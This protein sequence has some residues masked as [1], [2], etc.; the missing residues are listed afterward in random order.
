MG[1]LGDLLYS[2]NPDMA[3]QLNNK[4]DNLRKSNALHNDIVNS[5]RTIADQTKTFDGYLMA[6]TAMQYHIS[7]AQEELENLPDQGLPILS[8]CIADNVEE[9]EMDGLNIKLGYDFVKA[10]A[11]RVANIVQESGTYVSTIKNGFASFKSA[12][13]EGL[14][15]TAYKL[16]I[17]S[18]GNV[19]RLTASEGGI[20]LTAL[21]EEL[22]SAAELELSTEAVKAAESVEVAEVSQSVAAGTEAVAGIAEEVAVSGVALS[23]LLTPAAVVLFAVTEVISA[24]HAKQEHEKLKEALGKI[25]DLQ[26]K[27]DTSLKNLKTAFVSLLKSAQLDIENYNDI[28]K[29]LSA[30]EHLETYERSFKTTGIQAFS[31]NLPN[32]KPDSYNNELQGY[33]TA[34]LDNLN[35]AIEFIRNHALHDSKM[36]NIISKIRTHL[37]KTGETEVSEEFMKQLAD[38]EDVELKQVKTWNEFRKYIN[39]MASVLSRYHEAIKVENSSSKP[40]VRQPEKPQFG[41][42]NPN[43]DPNPSLFAI[44]HPLS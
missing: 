29:K 20:E 37:R 7:Y 34:V 22:G 24:I 2:D 14:E 15:R 5:Y 17:F 4:E 31:N 3:Q 32:I 42:A 1:I 28:L 12:L 23:S 21:S 13:Q 39:S 40:G 44:P 16:D 6:L 26:A 35:E 19:Q 30:L 36:S 41:E 33:A 25:D 9:L 18:S 11:S 8:K 38:V 27:T 10:T 43:Y